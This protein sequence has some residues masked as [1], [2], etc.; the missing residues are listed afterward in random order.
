MGRELKYALDNEHQMWITKLTR[1]AS[2]TT[3]AKQAL[4]GLG[5]KFIKVNQPKG[6]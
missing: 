5:I 1:R 3:E 6:E 2:L 4:E